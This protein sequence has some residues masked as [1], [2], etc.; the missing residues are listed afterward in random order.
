MLLLYFPFLRF[1]TKENYMK[2]MNEF[3]ERE[4]GNMKV[5]LQ[6]ISV[7]SSFIVFLKPFSQFC[8]FVICVAW[9]L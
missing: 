1:G 7:R 8:S 9:L 2:F 5:F 6:E 4:W 3:L